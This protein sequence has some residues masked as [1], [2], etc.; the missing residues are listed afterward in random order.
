MC[1]LFTE[2]MFRSFVFQKYNHPSRTITTNTSSRSYSQLLTPSEKLLL[3]SVIH[4]ARRVC[5]ESLEDVECS[6]A[7][8]VVDEVVRGMHH[9]MESRDDTSDPLEM[10][11]AESP[12]NDE[13]RMYD[14]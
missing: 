10:Y 9:R 14:V 11:C 8:D 2:Q 6:V 4:D 12:E 7:W 13:C 1:D 3:E 5:A